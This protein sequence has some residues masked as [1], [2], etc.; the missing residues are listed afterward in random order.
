M[1]QT[2]NRVFT[3]ALNQRKGYA[4]SNYVNRLILASAGLLLPWTAA[5]NTLTD[6]GVGLEPDFPPSHYDPEIHDQAW[7]LSS[8]CVDINENGE[9]ACRAL[10]R[11][12]VYGCG[13][14]NAQNCSSSVAHVHKWNGVDLELISA[15]GAQSDEPL[16]MNNKGWIAGYSYDGAVYPSGGGN[17][18]IWRNS[19]YRQVKPSLVSFLNDKGDFIVQ[20]ATTSGGVTSYSGVVYDKFDV[21]IP[22]PGSLL[23]PMALNKNRDVVGGQV[24]QDYL[25]ELASPTGNEV[26]EISGVGWLL[27]QAEVDALP[28]TGFGLIDLDRDQL[29][30]ALFYRPMG[31]TSYKTQ[32][33]DIN[34]YGDFVVQTQFG[35]LFSGRLCSREGE[36]TYN[37]V[38]GISHTVPW[39]CD[40]TDYHGGTYAGGKAFR[41]INNIGDAVGVFTPGVYQYQTV[42]PTHPW[43]WLRNSAGGWDE[44]NANDLLPA[45]SDYTIVSINDIND[46][47]EIV[48]T[49]ENPEGQQRGCILHVTEP[50]IPADTVKPALSISAPAVGET[51]SGVVAI[52]ASAWDRQSHIRYVVFKIDDV[53]IGR[54]RDRP[55]SVEWDTA[56]LAAGDYT[57]KAVAVDRAGNRRAKKL[58]VT[59]SGVNPP[60]PPPP[61]GTV[62]EGEGTLSAIG[63]DYIEV[64]GL[65]MYITEQTVIK[66][67]DVDDFELGLPVQYKAVQDENDLITATDIEVN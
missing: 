49:C 44:Y 26:P 33:F 6:V 2:T 16:V 12:P 13:W 7:T 61:V 46:R 28:L 39:V 36:T 10:A 42:Y 53:V 15:A 41:G 48:G 19:H 21:E 11:G 27:N 3:A 43:V 8:S 57:I 63:V 22:F 62:L 18:R 23:Y 54:D 51:V 45:G 37:D 34:E 66:F 65:R 56:G 47:R 1:R 55:F 67:N 40:S 14:R 29:W 25:S 60:P 30:S 64:D 20:S 58:V 5:A 4:M 31:F 24:I 50:A 17:G 59:V 9:A 32:A 38:Y 35:G 52:Q